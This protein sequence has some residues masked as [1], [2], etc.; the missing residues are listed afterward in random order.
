MS[1]IADDQGYRVTN[2]E[3]EP[4]GSGPV[5][6]RETGK[7]I[8]QQLVSGVETQYAIQAKVRKETKLQSHFYSR[9]KMFQVQESEDPATGES[10]QGVIKFEKLEPDYFD[11]ATGAEDLADVPE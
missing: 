6:N 2:M 3:S 10:R 7:A 9:K 5:A 8:V 11:E 1:Y 4:I